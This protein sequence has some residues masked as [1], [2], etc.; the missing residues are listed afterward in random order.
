[1]NFSARLHHSPGSRIP[2]GCRPLRTAKLQY[3]EDQ[4]TLYLQAYIHGYLT[5][6]ANE[7]YPKCISEEIHTNHQSSMENAYM[8]RYNFGMNSRREFM[9]DERL[10]LFP[11]KSVATLHTESVSSNKDQQLV[12]RSGPSESLCFSNC[13]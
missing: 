12:G 8:E 6:S 10:P 4:L 9:Q 5:K 3:E 2:K 7:S 1:M 13:S 11:S